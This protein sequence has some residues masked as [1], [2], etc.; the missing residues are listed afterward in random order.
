MFSLASDEVWE[1]RHGEMLRCLEPIAE[2][3]PE[4]DAEFGAGVH[5]A[6]ESVTTIATG[7][8]MRAAADLA[9]DHMTVNVALGTIG[10]EWYLR[11]VE[12]SQQLSLV[13]K[14]PL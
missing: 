4:C 12:H 3:V 2:R 5:Q 9:L 13:G 7:V 10:I 6:E 14:Q 1:I 11:P 8:G